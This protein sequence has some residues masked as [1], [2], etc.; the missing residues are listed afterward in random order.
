MEIP[1]K[2]LLGALLASALLLGASYYVLFPAVE[3]TLF[4]STSAPR[5]ENLSATSTPS[6]TST[7]SSPSVQKGTNFSS[8][9]AV[10]WKDSEV[11]FVL[12]GAAL[13][14]ST[15]TLRLTV[16][17][18]NYA[19]CAPLRLRR[20]VNEAGDLMAP[21]TKGFSFPDTGSC[22]GS[23][24]TTYENQEVVFAVRRENAP[25]IFTTTGSANLFFIISLSENG[26]LS[27]EAAPTSE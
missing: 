8:P 20:L 13:D 3:T 27:V 22:T 16:T 14:A 4:S 12:T 2:W 26:T 6:T 24:R 10:T 17:T 7:S 21:L 23:A 11:T 9:Y 18:P 15:L 5:E 1:L 19:I 25:F